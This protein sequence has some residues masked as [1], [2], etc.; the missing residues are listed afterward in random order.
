MFATHNG[1]KETA[2][3][4]KVKRT[5]WKAIKRV[6]RI[7]M[8]Y[9][10]SWLHHDF[11]SLTYVVNL[12][13]SD[14]LISSAFLDILIWGS[15]SLGHLMYFYQRN[16]FQSKN[17]QN[18]WRLWPNSL[19]RS[20]KFYQ[21]STFR[22]ASLAIPLMFPFLVKQQ[23]L[24]HVDLKGQ[25]NIETYNTPNR[26]ADETEI[27]IKLRADKANKVPEPEKLASFK[28]LHFEMRHALLPMQ[29][30]TKLVLTEHTHI[31]SVKRTQTKHL[32]S[33]D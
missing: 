9:F 8:K 28:L 33:P 10:I 6:C 25:T 29:R 23:A 19:F 18:D 7:S 22:I 12:S 15:F 31:A 5:E 13:E 4:E 32:P 27:E 14:V 3:N 16:S 30:L 11:I 26:K 24:M 17:M 2:E 1:A 20:F 21:S